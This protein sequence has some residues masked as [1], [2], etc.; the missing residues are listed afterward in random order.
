MDR[1]RLALPATAV[2]LGAMSLTALSPA[3][4]QSPDASLPATSPAASIP[5]V[6]PGCMPMASMQPA[7]SLLPMPGT[8]ASPAASLLPGASMQP[9]GSILPAA[10][11]I[12]P[13]A[14]AGASE[15]P[16]AE[17][18]IG[19]MPIASLEPATSPSAAP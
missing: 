13:T 1:R 14:S 11:S 3:L 4:G 5:V 19:P 2:L 6:S 15:D 10:A 9:A 12:M 7:A 18:S 16:C 17:A 8:S